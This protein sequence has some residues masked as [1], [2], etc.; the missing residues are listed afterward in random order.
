MVGLWRTGVRNEPV[1][2][3][4]GTDY[5]AEI[6]LCGWRQLTMRLLVLVHNLIL[7]G[8]VR[9]QLTLPE[10]SVIQTWRFIAVN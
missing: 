10:S 6:K 8:D 4:E 3:L 1:T 5:D 2:K 7:G 9:W